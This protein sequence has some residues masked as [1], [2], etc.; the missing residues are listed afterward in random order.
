MVAVM[1]M[2]EI[3]THTHTQRE[4]ERVSERVAYHYYLDLWTLIT[5]RFC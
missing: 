4:R 5:P 2:C 1:F 3:H